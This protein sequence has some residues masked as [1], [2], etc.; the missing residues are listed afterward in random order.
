MQYAQEALT[1][2]EP[3][4]PAHSLVEKI[5]ASL[6]RALRAIGDG[7]GCHVPTEEPSTI[8]VE[9]SLRRPKAK[10]PYRGVRGQKRG[11]KRSRQRGESSQ[12]IPDNALVVYEEPPTEREEDVEERVEEEVE[13]TQQEECITQVDLDPQ[14]FRQRPRRV[15]KNVD[16]YTPG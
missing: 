13:A 3:D 12:S 8:V 5:K 4:A 16:R 9:P 14:P 6:S 15:R 1:L 10:L 7:L 2:L 11:G